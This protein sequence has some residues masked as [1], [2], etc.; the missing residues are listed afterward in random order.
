[1]IIIAG[2]YK[3][4][5]IINNKVWIG[6][7]VNIIKR[8]SNHWGGLLKNKNS[9]HLQ[10]SFNKY[11]AKAFEWSIVKEVATIIKAIPKEQKKTLKKNILFW[12]QTYLDSYESYNPEKGYNIS[13]TA[14]SCLGIK[15]SEKHKERISASNKGKNKGNLSWSKGLTKE[16]DER[17]KKY[18]E[19]LKGKEFTKEHCKNIS[20]SA[21]ECQNR[22]STKEK[23]S[24]ALKGKMAGNKNP[25]YG[26]KIKDHMSKEAYENWKLHLSEASYRIFVA[27]LKEQV[28]AWT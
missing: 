11:G 10:A 22:L 2:I 16:T 23:K 18:S 27:K 15:Q 24:K 25:M 6:S 26:E 19:T 20:M 13:P 8:L 14:G 1:M 9:P 7:S 17:I 21:K 3:I 12:E 28:E 4:R 5:N